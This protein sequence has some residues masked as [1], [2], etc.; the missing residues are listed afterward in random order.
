M[1][2]LDLFLDIIENWPAF[3]SIARK[4]TIR[5]LSRF[6]WPPQYF[7]KK[8][9]IHWIQYSIIFELRESRRRKEAQLKNCFT[10]CP[11]MFGIRLRKKCISLQKIAFWAFFHELLNWNWLF[12][13]I[14][15]HLLNKL[16]HKPNCLKKPIYNLQFMKKGWKGNFLEWNRIFS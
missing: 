1:K 14:F 6:C 12:Q 2:W 8:S 15:L 7:K 13:A 3:E 10:G 16:L 5:N 4:E 11:N 9:R